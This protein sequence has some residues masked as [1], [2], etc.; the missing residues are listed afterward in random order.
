MM[1]RSEELLPKAK[2]TEKV[3]AEHYGMF[4]K[5]FFAPE[6][7][8]ETSVPQTTCLPIRTL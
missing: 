8:W 1:L 7:H 2:F 6:L 5:I 3:K 4:L